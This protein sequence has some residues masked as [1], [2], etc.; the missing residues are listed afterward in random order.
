MRNNIE[1]CKKEKN[2]A[3]QI[4]RV[5][6]C[7][8]VFFVHFGQR[9]NAT[10]NIRAFFDFGAYGVQLFF[11]IS[12]YLCCLT[13][14]R[15]DKMN[16]KEY[17][18]K[19]AIAILPLYFLTIIYYFVSENILDYFFDII[20]NDDVG[21]GWFRY[22]FLLN[23]F[24]N[25]DTYFWSNLGITWTIPIFA[26]FYLIA[27]WIMKKVSSIKSAVVTWA[28]IFI[29]TYAISLFYSCTIIENLHFFFLGFIIYTCVYEKKF[30]LPTVV[31]LINALVFLILKKFLLAYVFIFAAVTLNLISCSKELTL[32]LKIKNIINLLDK[33]SY[34]FYLVHGVIFCSLLDRLIALGTNRL[35][36]A[37]IAIIVTPILTLIIGRFIEQPIQNFLRKK[38]LK[39]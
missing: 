38:L 21:L 20:P 14:F 17:Y 18:I 28:I 39:K 2:L 22:I 4:L 10:G 36:I 33:Y 25:S 7:L 19:R 34:T 6:A 24:I 15:K 31:I 5:T 37:E 13:F 3:I 11:L 29:S 30:R 35:L 1:T 9:I 16:V 26:F 32:P 27:P 23:G 8:M 12:G